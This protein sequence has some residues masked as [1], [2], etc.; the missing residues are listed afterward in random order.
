[1]VLYSTIIKDCHSL[2]FIFILTHEPAP[3]VSAAEATHHPQCAC[4]HADT[5]RLNSGKNKLTSNNFFTH[6][7]PIVLFFA[8][9]WIYYFSFL[10]EGHQNWRKKYQNISKHIKRNLSMP[11]CYTILETS[12]DSVTDDEKQ[13]WAKVVRKI[14]ARGCNFWSIR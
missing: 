6:L 3:A 13:N 10:I 9:F 14:N 7:T 2:F 12:H 11:K 4:C 1:M 5:H 8:N